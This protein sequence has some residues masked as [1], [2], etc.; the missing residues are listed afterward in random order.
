MLFKIAWSLWNLRSYIVNISSLISSA[1][2]HLK[3]QGRKMILGIL[4]SKVYVN[5]RIVCKFSEMLSE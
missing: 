1:T 3:K 5:W 2:A 4:I